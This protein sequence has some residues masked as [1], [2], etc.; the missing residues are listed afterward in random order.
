MEVGI[1]MQEAPAR[2]RVFVSYS[3]RDREFA[4]D[5]VL[6]LTACGFEAYIDREDI[7]AG[8]QWS[9]RLSGLIAQADTIVYVLS[10]DSAASPQCA[11]EV[12]QTL[13]LSKRLLPVVWRPVDE[14]HVPAELRRLNYVFFSGAGHSFAS[15]LSQL[16]TALRTDIGWIREHTRLGE[17]AARWDARGRS[18]AL[19]LRGEELDAARDWS[20]G[21]P[22]NAPPITDLQ[23]DFVKASWDARVAEEVRARRARTGLLA[24]VSA[25][26]L[27]MAGL[28]AG[29]G[30]FWLQ[31]EG[32]KVAAWASEARA[33]NANREL[34]DANLRLSAD[35]GLRMAPS[36]AY[37]DVPGG[38]FPV[39]ASFAGAV[40]R[41]ERRTPEG[42]VLQVASGLVIDGG[43]VNASLAGE[44]LLLVPLLQGATSDVSAE[45]TP[46]PTDLTP[47]ADAPRMPQ[48]IAT[49]AGPLPEGTKVHASLPVVAGDV[50]LEA[51]DLLWK[52][53][54]H[55]G[56]VAPFELW[57]LSAMLP[58]GGRAI[59]AGDV[60]CT[61]PYGLSPPADP[62]AP[63]W[64]AAYAVK[65]AAPG[66][67]TEDTA[68]AALYISRLISRADPYAVS[69]DHA[70]QLG[71]AGGPVFDL[72]SGRIFAIHL[73]SQPDPARPGRRTGIGMSLPM[74]LNLPRESLDPREGRLPP[75]CEPG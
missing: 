37:L 71:A 51:S 20:A 7:A 6:G 69:Y 22:A 41:V 24:A 59:V 23:A 56:G 58:P 73:Q 15:G 1:A 28:A 68:G 72:T 62:S 21:R 29:A 75:M 46:P 11:W 13:A 67:E 44:P 2:M 47:A 17:L 26:A 14:A 70:T 53:P 43:V 8:E 5:L 61:D 49:R 16:A 19:L 63:V 52:T 50:W 66:D 60:D 25:V 4:D 48:M 9:A 57:R 65:A 31:A 40:A 3:R 55:L 34:T 10:P 32:A 30:Y 38:W 54:D 27:V 33:L 64:A 35:I 42:E 18:P 12:E 36:D 74:L 39:A 45:A